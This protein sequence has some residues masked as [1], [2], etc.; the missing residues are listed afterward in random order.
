[1]RNCVFAEYKHKI[2]KLVR[3]TLWII[4]IRS[5]SHTHAYIRA[6]THKLYRVFSFTVHVQGQYCSVYTCALYDLR[7]RSVTIRYRIRYSSSHALLRTGTFEIASQWWVVGGASET[8]ACSR[9]SRAT[10]SRPR[11]NAF[12]KSYVYY[13]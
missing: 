5:I 13:H 10:R 4:Q 3:N 1:M 9:K 2:I 7:F 11:L 12:N 8:N 6:H